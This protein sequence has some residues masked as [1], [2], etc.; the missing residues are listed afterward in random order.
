M[1]GVE[2]HNLLRINKWGNAG[3]IPNNEDTSS[4]KSSFN[5]TLPAKK[6]T[7]ATVPLLG[8]YSS[9]L[10]CHLNIYSKTAYKKKA[11]A[12]AAAIQAASAEKKAAARPPPRLRRREEKKSTRKT[13]Q[14]ES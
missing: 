7:V 4:N 13:N 5:K 3:G 9:A 11:A 1:L 8:L 12:E 2:A 10:A 6:S 14:I